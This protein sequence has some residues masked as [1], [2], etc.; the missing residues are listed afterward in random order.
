VETAAMIVAEIGVDAGVGAAEVGVA[1]VAVVDVPEGRAAE[2]C[3]RQNM[4]RRKAVTARVAETTK[5]VAIAAGM[6]GAVRV[7]ISVT[8]ALRGAATVSRARQV[9][10]GRR[11]RNFFFPANRSR[12]SAIALQLPRRL[13]L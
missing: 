4:H 9:L 2:I 7:A 11:R 6:I 8:I 1:A 12:N 3:L 10:Q 13:L 5:I